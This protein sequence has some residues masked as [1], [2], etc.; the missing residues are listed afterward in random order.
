MNHI[1]AFI[2]LL[3]SMISGYKVHS[4]NSAILFN[5]A[6]VEVGDTF[7]VSIQYPLVVDEMADMEAWINAAGLEL[8]E[9]LKVDTTYINDQTWIDWQAY[10]IAFDTGDFEL[11]PI[12][13]EEVV[14]I[15]A[16]KIH[17]KLVD[18]DT[19]KAFMD[20]VESPALSFWWGD[21]FT[22]MMVGLILILLVLGYFWWNR[23]K[24]HQETAPII[25]ELNA[26]VWAL[27][28]LKQI[29]AQ[30]AQVAPENIKPF[31]EDIVQL[32]KKYLVYR[33]QWN[34]IEETTEDLLARLKK[35]PDFRRYRKDISNLLNTSDLVKFAK[36]NV[37][38]EEKNK[39][40]NSLE[41]IIK[42]TK[43][44]ETDPS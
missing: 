10:L 27:E 24:N 5:H 25:N 9:I 12:I 40:Q 35:H 42:A 13:M 15:P 14:N 36:A 21:Y 1:L 26:H 32:F 44:Q 43:Y 4:Q 29:E 34:A 28:Q 41:Q 23:K 33:Y 16:E 7:K 38:E 11:G 6:S 37:L 17:I 2:F 39:Q 18:V 3:I 8:Y 30:Y 20:I 22:W 19:T 31:F